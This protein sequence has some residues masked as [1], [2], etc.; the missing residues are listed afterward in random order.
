LPE[1]PFDDGV[2]V[3]GSAVRLDPL[4]AN[5]YADADTAPLV[6]EPFTLP[7]MPNDGEVVP[8]HKIATHT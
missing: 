3:E 2:I 5:R 1:T 6:R 8:L 4:V 7:L